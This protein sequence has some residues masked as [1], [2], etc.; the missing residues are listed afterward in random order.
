MKKLTTLQIGLFT[1]VTFVAGLLIGSMIDLPLFEKDKL[2]GS[3]GKVDRYRNVKMTDE[4]I[5]LRNELVDDT[6]K[7]IQYQKYLMF[8][9]Y[10]SVKTSYDVDK[11]LT[12]TTKVPEFYKIYYPYAGA[13]SSFK[14]YLE[15]AREDIL[16]A[17]NMISSL[18]SDTEVPVMRYLNEAINAIAR[19]KNHDAILMNYMT[20]IE[21]FIQ[22]NSDT[23]YPTLMDAHDLLSFNIIQTAVLTQNKP[24]LEYLNKKKLMNNKEG[25]KEIVADAG[26]KPYV[27]EQYAIDVNKLGVIIP[28]RFDA[29]FGSIGQY[30]DSDVLLSTR[31]L[32][33]INLGSEGLYDFFDFYTSEFVGIYSTEQT[34]GLY[35]EDMGTLRGM[36]PVK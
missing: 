2:S 17:Y 9:Y 10:Q 11:V 6:N 29:V 4:D 33:E 34:F 22:S 18:E 36:S 35:F 16:L 24:V 1:L 28:D 12:L 26:F 31:L 13:L 27:K 5:L 3:I 7:C 8:Y 15:P 32:D 25:L 30:L 20:A 21:T 23:T 14:V 19:I